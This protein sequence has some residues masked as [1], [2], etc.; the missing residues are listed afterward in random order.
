MRKEVKRCAGSRRFGLSSKR[1]MAKLK[2]ANLSL[3]HPRKPVGKAWPRKDLVWYGMPPPN[4]LGPLLVDILKARGWKHRGSPCH[5]VKSEYHSR[6]WNDTDWTWTMYVKEF[7][8]SLS[9]KSPM[10]IFGK[11]GEM[12]EGHRLQSRRLPPR[13]LWL[14][15]SS[16]FRVPR[17]LNKER[18]D[19]SIIAQMFGK[20]LPMDGSYQIIGY[21]GIETALKKTNLSVA[22]RGLAWFPSSY[23]LPAEKQML[24]RDMRSKASGSNYWICKPPNDYGGNG[25]S[26]FHGDDP[27]FKDL[28]R[29]GPRSGQHVVQQYLVDP[30][31]I[32][33]YKFHI[34]IHLAV[35]SLHPPQAFVQRNGQCLFATEQYNLSR[36]TTGDNF[37]APVHVTNMSLNATEENKEN[38]FRSKPFIG[39]GQQFRMRYLEQYLSRHHPGYD[40]T[41]L[42]KQIVGIA[43]DN[44]LYMA[45]APSVRQYG[46]FP[47]GRFFEIFG[48]DLMLD[49]HLN[50]YMCEVNTNPGLDYPDEIILGEPNP[51]YKKE[52]GACA[53]TWHDLMTLLGLDATTR[54]QKGSLK[55]W[56][57]VDF[58]SNNS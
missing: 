23:V 22:F 52:S 39:K 14:M 54:A 30:L 38:F 21:P 51:D 58:G 27:K 4:D 9:G 34:R 53:E 36:K 1:V 11:A 32:G 10:E 3:K 7:A 5:A 12:E 48:M 6:K 42:W 28:V 37:K 25:I 33:G 20:T 46:K 41:L 13:A 15:G 29:D 57:E 16:V 50:V 56:F 55:S 31:L 43:A 8:A 17:G 2:V 26:V 45:R 40:A 47:S 18:E 35:T 49:K 44:V 19:F 24:I